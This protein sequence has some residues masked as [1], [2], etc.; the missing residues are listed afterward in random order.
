[1]IEI[2]YTFKGALQWKR[3]HRLSVW[4]KLFTGK[5]KLFRFLSVNV[6]GAQRS[7]RCRIVIAQK[8]SLVFW[9]PTNQLADQLVAKRRNA[10]F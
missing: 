1:M 5:L 7:G 2:N 6:F 4:P 3:F 10:F 9:S 8:S